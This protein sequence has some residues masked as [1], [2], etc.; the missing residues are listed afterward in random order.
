MNYITEV[1]LKENGGYNVIVEIPKGTNSK[2]ELE[3]KIF[4]KVL[5]VRKVIGKYPFYYGCFPRTYAGDKDPL[6]MILVSKKK[7]K[8]LDIVNI[9]PI[10]VI[11]TIDNNEIDDKIICVVVDEKVTV[12]I[13]KILK[14]LLTYKGKDS[15]TTVDS[16]FYSTE[17]AIKLIDEANKAYLKRISKNTTTVESMKVDF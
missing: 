4:D 3:D 9:Q 14:F 10:G 6:D 16:T 12:N 17:E 1:Q 5:E 8:S 2:F 11:K 7:Y 15:N 13:K